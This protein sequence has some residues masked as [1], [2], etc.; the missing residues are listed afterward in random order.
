MSSEYS[1]PIEPDLKREAPWVL[2]YF[3][4]Y[5]VYLSFTLEN[6]ILHWFTLVFIPVTGLYLFQKRRTA[7]STLKSTLTTVGLER[8]RS[9]NG[10]L[11][12]IL[13]GLALS[14]LQLVLSRN[15]DVIWGLIVSGKVLILFPLTLLIMLLTAG[16]T[17]EFFFRGV[18]QTRIQHL[19]KSKILAVVVTS[20]LFGLYHLPYAYLNPRWPSH[21]NW[22]EAFGA[23]FGQ[24]VPMGLILGTLYVRTKNNLLACVL[25]HAL[26]NSLPGM[27]IVKIQGL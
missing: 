18:L 2:M 1:I 16:F 3:T 12:A 10:I 11:W 8:G 6:E 13:I 4:L 21:G 15:K 19:V 22:P 14:C 5:L 25:V 9:K 7:L 20:V 24:G 26:I 23:A 17:E 27:L